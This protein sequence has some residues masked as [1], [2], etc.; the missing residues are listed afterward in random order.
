MQEVGLSKRA[1]DFV[2]ARQ[3]SIHPHGHVPAVAGGDFA[4][5]KQ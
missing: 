1:L 5:G 3:R 2:L 4:S